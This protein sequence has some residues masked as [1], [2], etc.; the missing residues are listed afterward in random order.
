MIN[1]VRPDLVALQEVDQNTTRTLKVDQAAE[2]ARLTGLH[3]AYGK[4]MDYEGGGYGQAILSRYPIRHSE[5]YFL[6]S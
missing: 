1:S 6:P 4:A 3:F 5:V 2:L